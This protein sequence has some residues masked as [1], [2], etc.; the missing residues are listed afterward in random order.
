MRRGARRGRLRLT[1]PAP[2]AP[3]RDGMSNSRRTA[4]SSRGR[5]DEQQT[6]PPRCRRRCRRRG[7][8]LC[9]RRYS[10]A[11]RLELNQRRPREK[12]RSFRSSGCTRFSDIMCIAVGCLLL[13]GVIDVTCVCVMRSSERRRARIAAAHINISS[14]SKIRTRQAPAR[15]GTRQ[16]RGGSRALAPRHNASAGRR[17]RAAHRDGRDASPDS[18]YMSRDRAESC[19]IGYTSTTL[20]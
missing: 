8:A 1:G 16:R 17:G 13:T 19:H 5:Y 14:R 15:D 7:Y 18:P 6:R 12:L 20:T 4:S 3:A 11:H 2:Q 10:R 9:R